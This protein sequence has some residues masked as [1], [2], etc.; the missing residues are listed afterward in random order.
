MK[1]SFIFLG[2][3]VAALAG[4]NPGAERKKTPLDQATGTVAVHVL[5]VGSATIQPDVKA[6]GLLSTENEARYGFKISGV[7]DRIW[8]QEGQS[9]RKGQRLAALKIT[10]INEQLGQAEL[11]QEKARRDYQRVQ[12]L[13]RDSVATLEQVQN[14]KTTFDLTQKATRVV[15]FNQQYAYVYATADGIVTKK[16]ASEGEVIASGTPV[17]AIN[18]TS[19]SRDWTLELGLND[20]DWA[21]VSLGNRAVVTLDAFPG[22]TFK[23]TVFRKP[24]AA[25]PASGTFQVEVKL[26]LTGTKPSV[27]MFGRAT[28]QTG[29]SSRQTVIPYEAVVEANGNDAFVFVPQGKNRVRRVPIVIDRFDDHHVV[30][31]RGLEQV[32][33]VVVS[34]SA[35]LNES[36]TIQIVR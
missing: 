18:E 7:I 36:S 26:N 20:R 30:V 16:L 2:L 21:A 23:G 35:F 1:T 32:S 25:D 5:P 13:Y 11:G 8:V 17:L 14:A 22:R 24:T 33:A 10:E 6:T 31:K 27:G 15:A 29:R 9:F 34:N 12:N 28:L 19:N 3:T 4:C